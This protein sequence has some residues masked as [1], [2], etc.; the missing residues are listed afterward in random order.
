MSPETRFR[1]VE[2]GRPCLA[3]ACGF[4]QTKRQTDM[5][6]SCGFKI[7]VRTIKKGYVHEFRHQNAEHNHI[8]Y[9]L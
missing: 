2:N 5:Y 9:N 3:M 8:I 6:E 1:R 7:N 4:K